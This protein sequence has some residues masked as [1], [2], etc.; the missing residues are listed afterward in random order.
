MAAAHDA[1]VVGSGP[2]GLAAAV[3]LAE[4]GLSV[5]VLEM[6]EQPGGGLRTEELV[7]PGFHHDI[8]STV[9]ALAPI[10]PFLSRFSLDLVR[11]PAPLAH[12]LDDGTA[13]ML[14]RSLDRTARGLGRDAAAYRRLMEPL[15]AQATALAG[16]V[17]QPPLHLPRHPLAMARFGPP[18]LLPAARLARSGFRDQRA[19]ALF[20]GVAGH[21]MLPLDR[22]LSSAF[23]LVMLTAAHAG[24]WP[25][26]RGG[27]STVADT[28]LRRLRELGGEVRCGHQVRSVEEL[29]GARAVLLDLVPKGVLEV[30]GHR[31]PDRYRRRLERY[32][33]GAGVF[34]LDWTLEAPIPWR[35]PECAR[36][37]TV[38]LG[39]TLEEI[40]DGE[41][42]VSQGR[43]PERPFVILVQPTLFDP[44]R[45]PAGRHVAWAYCHVPNGST[46]DM[47][48]AVEKQVERFAP[49]FRDLVRSRSVWSPARLERREPNCVGGD[50]GGG[51]M[52]FRQVLARPVLKAVPYATPDPSLFICSAATP[53]G[54]AVH[55][56]CG[57]NAAQ[58]ALRRRF[59]RRQLR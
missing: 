29:D 20:A 36:A 5:Q 55:G 39:G 13:V 52:D 30:A 7:E 8:C 40:V 58:A 47:S 23:A 44:E 19:R 3:T 32:R 49:G 10:S 11:S 57:V 53:P 34:K 38:H 12:P 1:T 15:A 25:L 4:A 17:L 6:A 54:G 26:A 42:Q 56:M 51:L 18:A 43:H 31:F 48:E 59:A 16:E 35:S 37:A 9:M 50:I 45:A 46:S 24:G 21:S 22:P 33:L 2:N 28:L 41:W 14:E 27:S